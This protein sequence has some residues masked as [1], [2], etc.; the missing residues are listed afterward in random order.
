MIGDYVLFGFAQTVVSTIGY[1]AECQQFPGQST[2]LYKAN[3]YVSIKH[4]PHVCHPLIKHP[5]IQDIT[6]NESLNLVK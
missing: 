3:H 6:R 1:T 2:H 5:G 4:L